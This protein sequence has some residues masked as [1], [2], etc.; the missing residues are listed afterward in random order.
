MVGSRVAAAVQRDDPVAGIVIDPV[1]RVQRAVMIAQFVLAEVAVE[2]CQVVVCLEI[3]AVERE[4][5]SEAVDGFKQQCLAH[6]P[7][8]FAA[9]LLGAFEQRLA[10]RVQHAVVAAEV[11]AARAG[12]GKAVVDD[13]AEVVDSGLELPVLPVDESA[14]PG[15]G[16]GR[17]GEFVIGRAPQR[18]RGLLEASLPEVDAREVD[19]TLGPA[20][21]LDPFDAIDWERRSATITN[22]NAPG[23]V[24]D[25][26]GHWWLWYD[27]TDRDAWGVNNSTLLRPAVQAEADGD[28]I[29]S[30][31]LNSPGYFTQYYRTA[32]PDET[33]RPQLEIVYTR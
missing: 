6:S 15:D 4:R 10:E 22:D 17:D 12:L 18:G 3:L 25:R 31:R 27:G 11:E 16:P 26:L 21:G 29:L 23:P 9:Q 30:L 19:G 24:G 28:G 14:Q 1:L 13:A 32:D 7:V 8:A 2:L 33:R 20:E 5:A